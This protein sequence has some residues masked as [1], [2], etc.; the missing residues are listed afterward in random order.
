MSL[1]EV[2]SSDV[3]QFFYCK[4]I[5]YFTK[6]LRARFKPTKKMEFG[7]EGERRAEI[8]VSDDERVVR[9]F[10]I[11]DDALALGAVVD[12]LIFGDGYVKVVEVKSS[13]F[14]RRI[15][16]HHKM[17]L[18]MQVFLVRRRFPNLRVLSFVYYYDL[19]VFEE[20][21]LDSR[22]FNG[23]L[24][25]VEVIRDIVEH[26]IVPVGVFDGRCADCEFKTF[27][28]DMEV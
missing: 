15:D 10:Y 3:K 14:S 17:Q 22:H 8:P 12:A 16:E 13:R 27:C 19:G 4:R 20:I 18:A 25:A 26:E 9:G 21:R 1:I 23:F 28:L 11:F 6:V 7:S 5:V 24:R 2:F